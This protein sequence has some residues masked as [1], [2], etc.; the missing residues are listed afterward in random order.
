ME[1]YGQLEVTSTPDSGEWSNLYPWYLLEKWLGGPPELARMQQPRELVPDP[2]EN[3]K[4]VS[5]QQFNYYT[6]WI[7]GHPKII[8]YRMEENLWPLWRS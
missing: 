8:S 3:R 6:G 4:L 7:A 5:S 1:V 2:V